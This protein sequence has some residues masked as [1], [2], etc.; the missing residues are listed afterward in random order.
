LYA[1]INDRLLKQLNI[2]GWYNCEYEKRKGFEAYNLYY[3]EITWEIYSKHCKEINMILE[4]DG[5]I[6]QSK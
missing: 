4:I 2:D 6:K 1:E 5:I 3:D